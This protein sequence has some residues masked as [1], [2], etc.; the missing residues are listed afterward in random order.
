MRIVVTGTRGI[1]GIEG[2]V[3]THCENLYPLVQDE[4]HEVIVVRRPQHARD[5]KTEYRGVYIKDIAVLRNKYLEAFMHTF[6]SVLYAKKVKADIVHIHAIGP[7]LMVPLAR[8]LGMK[9]VVTHH[10][11]DYKQ[12]KWGKVAKWV[13]RFGERCA[14]RY[15]SH[16]IVVSQSI[17][18]MLCEK[19][20]ACTNVSLIYNGVD[21]VH[22]DELDE[23]YIKTLHVA[24]KGYILAVGRLTRGKA[25]DTLIKAF[26]QLSF[27][28]L[29][30]VIAGGVQKGE[31]RYA[32][33]LKSLA[34]EDK[35]IH[36][37]GFVDKSNLAQLY[38]H[39]RLFV[40]PSS[41]EGLPIAL[42]EAMSHK[43]QVLVSRI[44]ANEEVCLPEDCYFE[45]GNVQDL[46]RTMEKRLQSGTN[47]RCSYDMSRYDW[48]QIAEAT[49]NVYDIIMPR[50]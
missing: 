23:E 18:Q 40:L 39:A 1:P 16:I 13:L 17:K 33:L 3:E 37:L 24:D 14:V 45:C 50:Q 9:V 46:C 26:R 15:A 30:L 41:H 2:G 42:L 7:A 4:R 47:E 19:Y 5:K 22:S 31:E 43:C 10:G 8:L 35:R 48:K 20:S 25:F 27:T 38:A 12:A 44:P 49:R 32:E 34:G 36:L 21:K 6:L 28:S 29:Q 11:E